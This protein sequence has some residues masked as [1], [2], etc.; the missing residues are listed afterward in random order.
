M[1][2]TTFTRL[3]LRDCI[4]HGVRWIAP[5]RVGDFELG[6]P[7]AHAAGSFASKLVGDRSGFDRRAF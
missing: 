1:S 2:S 3:A 4:E 7:T 5:A 6:L